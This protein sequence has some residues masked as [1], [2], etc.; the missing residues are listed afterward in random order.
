[1]LV[2]SIVARDRVAIGVSALFA[3]AIVCCLL[4]LVFQWGEGGWFYLLPALL[5]LLNLVLWVSATTARLRVDE[6]GLVRESGPP[7]WQVRWP[8]VADLEVVRPSSWWA[9][10][11]PYL[12][13]HL[14][15]GADGSLR[16]RSFF[17]R[18][19]TGIPGGGTRP[20]AVPVQEERIQAILDARPEGRQ[21]VQ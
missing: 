14:A 18:L 8:E 19:L 11:H 2:E 17:S 16:G 7:R 20:L 10:G 6:R 15:P 4:L 3:V 12:I 13:V 9:G 1:M 21:A 5:F